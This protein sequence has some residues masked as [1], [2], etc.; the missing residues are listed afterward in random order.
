MALSGEKIAALLDGLADYVDDIEHTKL[1]AENAE[2]GGRVDQMA[3]SYTQA[4]GE[5]LSP[6][7]REKLSSL[8]TQSLDE[9]LKIAKNRD[10]SPDSLGGP[11]ADLDATSTAKTAAERAQQAEDRFDNWL[12]SD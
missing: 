5:A 10:E 6:G 8:D 9:L 7:V 4:T 2:R 1:A 11:S 12:I 3:A